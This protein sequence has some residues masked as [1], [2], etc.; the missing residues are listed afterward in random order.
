MHSIREEHARDAPE[1]RAVNTAAFGG[2]AEPDLVAAL[3]T[4]AQPLVSLVAVDADAVVGHILFSPVTLPSH[5]ALQIMGLAPMA[6]RPDRQRLG[7]GSSLVRAGL[8][9]CRGLGAGA[10]VVLGHPA[11]YPRFGFVAASRFGLRSEY[12]VPDEAFMAIELTPGALREA[13]GTI[14]YHRAFAGV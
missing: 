11:Y 8:E 4:Q 3:R 14:R 6:V 10:V 12:D 5:P 7:I 2:H 1:I 9:A 13:D